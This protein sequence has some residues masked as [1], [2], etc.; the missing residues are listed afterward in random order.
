MMSI[1]RIVITGGPSAGKTTALS[2]IEEAFRDRG[3]RVLIIQET[4]TELISSGVAPWTCGSRNLYQR[5]QLQLQLEKE[6]IYREAAETMPDEKILIVCDRG[7]M[8]NRAYMTGPD[9]AA[10][11]ADLQLDEV[12]LRDSYDAVFHL[13]T[14][15]K[16]AEAFYTLENNRAR[17]ETPEEARALDD[18]VIAAWTGHPHLRIIGNDAD[19]EEKM[20]RLIRALA[21]FL[22][23]PAPRETKRRYLLHFPDTAALEKLPGCRKVE[24]EQ[25]YLASAPDTEIRVR[26]RSE[27]GINSYY[28]TEKRRT[29]DGQMAETEHRITARE[30]ERL[31]PEKDPERASI[32]KTRYCLSW[33]DQYF[34]VDLYP[35]WTEQAIAEVELSSGMEEAHLPP[36]LTVIREVTGEAAYE[37]SELAKHA[38][39]TWGRL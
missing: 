4:A 33:E 10:L 20:Q 3:W 11:L 29:G 14:A 2:R 21:A 35:F 27:G 7:A 25:F 19:F 8:D 15:A 9:F 22:G 1:T 5:F 6:R 17:T 28:Y 38:N 34:A 13:V 32:T 24:I 36:E 23:E 30:Y 26:R 39:A 18:A 37:I 12:V 31:L 16:G